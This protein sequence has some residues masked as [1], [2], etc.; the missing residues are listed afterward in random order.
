MQKVANL[1]LFIYNKDLI[2][3]KPK[4]WYMTL[5]CMFYCQIVGL[6]VSS[7]NYH[8]TTTLTD[9]LFSVFEYARITPII[10]L[11]E[12]KYLGLGLIIVL[13]AVD[14]FFIYCCI[15]LCYSSTKLAEN[16]Q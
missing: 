3:R 15:L 16:M 12:I 6:I 7:S 8:P 1:F 10:S 2:S 14:A 13:L 5:S 9:I 11:L 4:V